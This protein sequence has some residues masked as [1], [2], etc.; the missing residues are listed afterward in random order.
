MKAPTNLEENPYQPP[1]EVSSGDGFSEAPHSFGW[2]MANGHLWVAGNCCV[3]MIDLFSGKSDETM[4]M[5][6]IEVRYRPWWLRWIP[7]AAAFAVLLTEYLRPDAFDPSSAILV[8]AGTWI[9]TLLISL[10]QPK[11]TVRFFLT[12]RTLRV[13]NR[14]RLMMHFLLIMFFVGSGL[15]TQGPSWLNLISPSFGIAW[16]TG[17]VAGFWIQRRLSCKSM[18]ENWFRIHGIHRKA[19]THL[20]DTHAMAPHR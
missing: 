19:I 6:M 1:A 8:F 16:I 3:P 10:L 2:K 13:R 14:Y 15:A 11:C 4:S 17:L 20:V 18:H 9:I 7:L 5:R 12:Q